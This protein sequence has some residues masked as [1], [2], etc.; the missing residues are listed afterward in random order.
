MKYPRRR[1]VGGWLLAGALVVTAAGGTTPAAD[2]I[3]VRKQAGVFNAKPARGEKY[4]DALKV[5]APA[6][7]FTLADPTGKNRIALSSFQGHKP[8]VLIF[9]SCT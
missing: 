9:A 7:D 2:R 4:P 8:V 1:V 6:P 5:G 3:Q